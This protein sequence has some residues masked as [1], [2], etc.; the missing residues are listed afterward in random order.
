MKVFAPVTGELD[1]FDRKKSS[2]I[3]EKSFRPI[4]SETVKPSENCLEDSIA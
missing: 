1:E 4:S 2:F 3:V